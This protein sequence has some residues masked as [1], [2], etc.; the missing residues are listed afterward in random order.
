MT[1]TTQNTLY[2]VRPLS[3][4]DRKFQLRKAC[5]LELARLARKGGAK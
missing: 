2:R 3:A 5:S 4:L 1:N